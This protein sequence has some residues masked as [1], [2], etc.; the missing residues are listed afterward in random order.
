V[1]GRRDAEDRRLMFRGLILLA[2]L[3]A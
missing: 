2:V 1:L 3:H